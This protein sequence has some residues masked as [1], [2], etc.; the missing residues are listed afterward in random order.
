MMNIRP[1]M[2]S[3]R[4]AAGDDAADDRADPTDHV[5]GVRLDR[6]VD[7]R[8]LARASGWSGFSSGSASPL[9]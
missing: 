6:L 7:L 4:G 9:A 5:A 3:E 8:G 2:P 1:R